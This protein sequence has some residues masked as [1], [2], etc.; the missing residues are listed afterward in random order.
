MNAESSLVV[1]GVGLCLVLIAFTS[2]VDAALSAIS[3]HRLNL[4]KEENTPRAKLVV[5]LL[6]GPYRFKAAILLLNAAAMIAATVFTL[7]LV[8]H[9]DLGWRLGALLLLLLLIMIF[10]VALPKA[11][12]ARNPADAGHLLAGPMAL[13]TR[14]LWPLI[15]VISFITNPL[16]RRLSGQATP[17]FPLVTEEEL[18][19]LVNVGEE[20]GLIE[21]DEREMIEGI[22]SFGDTAVS[23]VMVPRVDIIALDETTTLDEALDVVIA[24]G[25]SRIPVYRDTIDRIVGI[26]YVKDLLPG[27]RAGRRDQ[28][29]AGLLRAP[30][31]VPET[32]KV[33]ALLKELQ[34]RKVHLAIAVDE[35]GGTAGLVT[36]EDLL[37]EIVGDIQDEYDAEEPSVQLLG[38]GELIA[39]ARVPI[40]DIN[41]LTGLRLSSE[42]SDR[43]GGMV[44]E[45][46]GRVPKV[47]D[48]VQLPD[49]VTITVLSVEGLRPRQLRITYP[50]TEA[51]VVS[52]P[53]EEPVHH[54]DSA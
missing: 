34:A 21:P 33:D 47:G 10:S 2:A 43:I 3:R 18:L 52:A 4:L 46:L 8:R 49:R 22:F 6:S 54:E 53:E 30:Y 19:L 1:V 26:L 32:M 51:D 23:E 15:G 16:I 36:I 11:L 40:D 25:H 50:Q 13:M 20:E 45:R 12:V 29:L 9:L 37:E 35:Y 5:Q 31:F 38:E 42:E 24:N 48:E 7:R 17:K 27:L 28:S 14:L 39:D 44:Y 41:D